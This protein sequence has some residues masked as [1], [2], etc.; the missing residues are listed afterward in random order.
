MLENFRMYINGEWQ[1]DEGCCR[2]ELR[3]P[4]DGEIFGLVFEGGKPHAD[5]AI[6][7]ARRAFDDSD[8]AYAAQKRA[9][10]L[11]GLADALEKRRKEFI[12]LETLGTGKVI[13]ESRYDI[14]E[15]VSCL[16]YFADMAGEVMRM[17]KIGG[18]EDMDTYLIREPA[19]VCGLIVPWNYPIA[20]AVWKM[21]PALAAG[22]TI[23]MKPS[24][25]TPATLCRLFEIMDGLEI[26]PGVTNLVL[27]E[28][29]TVGDYLA[30][31][32]DMDMVSFTGST[33]T[34]RSVMRGAAGNIKKIALE[35]GGKSPNIIFSD[36]DMDLAIENA[37][38][39]IFYNQGQVCSA[40]SR[41]LVQE[42]IYEKFLEKL[43]RRTESISVGDG[44]NPSSQMGPL[45]SESHMNKVLGFI[46]SGV[47]AGA[48]L[49]TGG[50]RLTGPGYENGWFISPAIFDKVDR[51]MR[52]VREEIFGPVLTVQKFSTEEEAVKIA[53]DT[54]FGLAG[55]V[56]TRD[57]EK[58]I[59]V[60]RKIKAGVMWINT[61]NITPLYAPWGGYRQ[62]G[63]GREMGRWGY[64]EFT[65]VKQIN[66]AK[67][68]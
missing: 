21:A 16:R 14:D 6:K 13:K 30:K 20:T 11:N 15:S 52:I 48:R 59:R 4:A 43:V 68:Q 62:S 55:G 64:D 66:I 57:A 10:F 7:A 37:M 9:D 12:V 63:I 46:K 26:P 27:G 5:A 58:G 3:N 24:S 2:R 61:Y 44:R 65:E 1:S 17:E 23:V 50:E 41:L 67:Q 47:D 25:E 18:T 40:G 8:W 51:D 49:L 53:N 33:E 36:A 42:E 54:D 19:G 31:S 22:N 34:G 45:I 35:L 32:P 60:C 28:G 38:G 29:R 56:F 39:A